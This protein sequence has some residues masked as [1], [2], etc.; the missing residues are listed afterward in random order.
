MLLAGMR[1]TLLFVTDRARCHDTHAGMPILLC[2]MPYYYGAAASLLLR[3]FSL[4]ASG[5]PLLLL[6]FA[7]F[8]AITLSYAAGIRHMLFAINNN[9]VTPEQNACRRCLL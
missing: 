4:V 9:I 8:F 2:A 7:I 3:Y 5:T 6:F 1:H